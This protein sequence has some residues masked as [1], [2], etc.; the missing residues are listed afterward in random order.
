[1][2]SAQDLK[3]L[4]GENTPEKAIQ[5]AR[6][7][8]SKGRPEQAVQ[9]LKEAASRLGGSP[10]LRI[11]LATMQLAGGRTREA[12]ESLRALL[13]A[14]PSSVDRVEEFVGWARTQHG[15]VEPLYEP[16]AEGYVARRN[17]KAALDCLE[18]IPRK[19]LEGGVDARLA[20][21]NRYLEKGTPVP[22]AAL[23]TLY[24]AAVAQE[25]LGNWQKALD[26]YARVLAAS[27]TEFAVVDER[28]KGLIARHYKQIALR[29][30][31]ADLLVKTDHLDRAREEHL[32]ALE[33]DARSAPRVAQFLEQRLA[34]SPGDEGLTWDLVQVRRAEGDLPQVLAL[35][36]RLAERGAR[37]ADIEKMLEELS[38]SG[39]DTVDTQ[40]LMSRVARAQG[41][42][43]RAVSAVVAALSD[44]AG[45]RAIAALEDVIK[46]FPSETRPYQILA[47]HHLK[48]GR[49]DRCL[50]VYR[51]LRLADAG[52]T[53][54]ILTKLQS[55]LLADPANEEAMGMLEELGLESGD[56]R[57][58]VPLLRRRLRRGAEAATEALA[59]LRPMLTAH[60][61]DR[62]PKLAA[63]E[64][65]LA[66]EDPA[67]AWSFLQDL[68]D[69][70]GPAD[71]EVLRLI[72]LAAGSSPDLYR[73]ALATIAARAPQWR[74][75]VEAEFALA[76]AA[77][78]AGQFRD[79][80]EGFRRAA[81]ACPEAAAVC[82][83]AVRT[84]ARAA[85]TAPAEETGEKGALSAVLAEALLDAG[86]AGAAADTLR[87]AGA[88]PPAAAARLSKRLTEALR[89]DRGNLTLRAAL[90]EVLAASGQVPRALEIARAGLAGREDSATAP[91]VM[92]YAAVL[93]RAGRLA[94]ATRA[95][96]AAVRR[97]ASL[98][99]EA[100]TCLRRIL[101]VDRA[102]DAGYLALGRLLLHSG[103]AKEAIGALMSAWSLRSDLGP[104]ILKDLE[105]ADRLLPGDAG[106]AQA[107]ARIL[108][109]QGETA[110]AAEVLGAALG[111]DP[112]E[113]PALFSRLEAL[114]SGHPDCARAQLELARACALQGEPSRAAAALRRAHE[115]DGSL[116]EAV[117][118]LVTDLEERF[119]GS[120]E[121]KLARGHMY[122][123]QG[124]RQ[125]A[126]DTFLEVVAAGGAA[127]REGLEGLRR[128][129]GKER[130]APAPLHLARARAC[131]LA[132]A[133]GESVEAARSALEL[134]PELAASVREVIDAVLAAQGSKAE[135]PARADA[136]LA[137]AEA[138]AR[139]QDPEAAAR[140]VAAALRSDG[141]A[142]LRAAPL[143]SELLERPPASPAAA[144]ALAEVLALSGDAAAA[145]TYLDAALE[146]SACARDLDLILARRTLAI[147][148]G[149][150]ALARDLFRRAE[151]AAGSRGE[152]LSR[153]HAE[154]RARIGTGAGSWTLP[155]ELPGPNAERAAAALDRGDYAAAAEA[156]SGARPCGMKA[157][158]LL[159]CGRVAEAAACLKEVDGGGEGSRVLA[160]LH[161]RAVARE[162]EG[163]P[164]ALMAEVS[165]GFDTEATATAQ[166]RPRRKAAATA[167]QGGVR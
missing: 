116:A 73:R 141:A 114:A 143:V 118:V 13:K 66:A 28:I 52:S 146:A 3:D 39:K 132:G 94:E 96:L 5:K 74:Q 105:R 76:E 47:D 19:T 15:D 9:Y 134:S 88:V 55:V 54:T 90:V 1:M 151:A 53:P 20:N 154:A 61:E 107:R 84:L 93:A 155:P 124:K 91:L 133:L 106:L 60:P 43:S 48:H 23:P 148:S 147:S 166:A 68:I 117:A 42:S 140:D 22:R 110:Q 127:A 109:S 95:C 144:R 58:A 137:R 64:A 36:E 35:C 145:A 69:P 21:L 78:R 40:L 8:A 41:K 10:V 160:A 56:L 150:G 70:E 157:W 65:A 16:L 87:A 26:A 129:C 62:A 59:R 34:V 72:V 92:A 164:P 165:I 6:R 17:F 38:A 130:R 37:L 98:G 103:D 152:L 89:A 159:R 85:A 138:S 77:G 7:L 51:D 113:V 44:D 25:A 83:D 139:A 18:R 136:L 121:P 122:E 86:D 63:S 32:K 82:H 111:H 99:P 33:V 67:T 14:A 50:Q 31:Y 75:C 115:L 104:Q 163:R 101:A 167:R 49:I 12:A 120:P 71:P 27:P 135:G 80:V 125:A 162:L 100:I 81:A 119:P 30:A 153:L 126:A 123:T 112:G 4:F 108:E 11:E 45:E 97:E 156:L 57:A 2:L 131:R 102:L 46:A 79:A 161:D 142:A 128:L 29:L 24:F 149:D 158:V